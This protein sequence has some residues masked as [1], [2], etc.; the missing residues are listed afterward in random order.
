M[1]E[2]RKK[3]HQEIHIFR[4]EAVDGLLRRQN[5]RKRRLYSEDN[6]R[7]PLTIF[8]RND[9]ILSVKVIKNAGKECKGTGKVNLD[10][11]QGLNGSIKA[12]NKRD[13]GGNG[14]DRERG[15]PFVYNQQT[16]YEVYE[17]WANLPE[18]AHNDSEPLAGTPFLEGDGGSLFVDL[19][20]VFV[21]FFLAGKYLYKH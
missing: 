12:V 19:N 10:V 2:Y 14:T 8:G 11:E 1:K 4:Y 5:R 9:G 17:Q 13:S 18:H 7:N 6:N 3:A 16:A 20:E 21:L 15:I